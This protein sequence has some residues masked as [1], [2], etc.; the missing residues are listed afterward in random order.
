MVFANSSSL[1]AG[2]VGLL[3]TAGVVLTILAVVI[4]FCIRGHILNKRVETTSEYVKAIKALNRKYKFISFKS[5]G[6]KFFT[7]KSKRA[8]DTFDY[9]KGLNAYIREN[10]DD[11]EQIV[12]SVETN[13]ELLKQYK[14]EI[15]ALK[16]TSDPAIAKSVK[17][18]LKQFVKR[19]K[20]IGLELIKKPITDYSLS[21]SWGYTS[22]AGRNSYRRSHDV[23]FDTIRFIVKTQKGDNGTRNDVYGG[24]TKVGS[25]RPASLDDIEDLED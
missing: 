4:F 2:Y 11:F 23:N 17:M 10:L 12:D 24:K 8:F 3:V 14:G 5:C 22:P 6:Y 21:L 25:N 19:E 1:S 18:K 13:R 9:G 20:K 7:L 16:N 15:S